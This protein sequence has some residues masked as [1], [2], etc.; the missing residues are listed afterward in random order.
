MSILIS[1]NG[2]SPQTIIDTRAK[3]MEHMR[4]LDEAMRDAAPHGRN[5]ATNLEYLAARQVYDNLHRAM[6]EATRMWVE[7]TTAAYAAKSRRAK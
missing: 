4:A 1:L 5:Y 2:D 3:A 7:D 6:H